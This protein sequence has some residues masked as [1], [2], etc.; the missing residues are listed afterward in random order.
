MT[1]DD[2][3]PYQDSEVIPTVRSLMQDRQF[4]SMLIKMRFESAPTALINWC[5]APLV[6][7]YLSRQ[8]HNLRSIHDVQ[9]RVAGYVE[10]M[11]KQSVTNY[12]VTGLEHMQNNKAHLF[13]STHRDIVLD[14]TLVNYALYQA[15]MSTVQIAIGDNLLQVPFI[16]KLMRL[17]KSFLVKRGAQTR[18]EKYAHLQQLSHYIH[19]VLQEQNEHVWLAQRE[20]RAKDGIDKTDMSI[21]KMLC[22]HTK[23][24]LSTQQSLMQMRIAPVAISYEWDPCDVMKANELVTLAQKGEYIKQPLEDINSIKQGIVGHKGQIHVAFCPPIEIDSDDIQQIAH[25]ID[26]S[27]ATHYRLMK[28]NYAAYAWLCRK[29]SVAPR[30]DLIACAY[31][32]DVL[33][34]KETELLARVDGRSAQV[35]HQLMLGYANPVLRLLELKHTISPPIL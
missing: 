3:R 32:E 13:L 20:G 8:T 24:T 31:A 6:R 7:A 34:D 28:T 25:T 27:I 11:L 26:T 18:N 2:I 35:V 21:L 30:F 4:I 5:L 19:Y 29:Q 16:N 14:P 12:S 17:N 15:G 10:W 9:L 23:K 22:L 1:F 33:K